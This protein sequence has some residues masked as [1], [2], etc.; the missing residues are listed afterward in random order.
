MFNINS[1]NIERITALFVSFFHRKNGFLCS[2]ILFWAPINKD[3][4]S[5]SK[6][7]K[8][9]PHVNVETAEAAHE[10]RNK[11]T[12]NLSCHDEHPN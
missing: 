9:S 1:I 11:D 2:E 6:Y 4:K 7:I 12:D 10:K 8:Q 3:S 5:Y